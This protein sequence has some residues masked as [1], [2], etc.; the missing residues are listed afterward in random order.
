MEEEFQ[1]VVCGGNWWDSSINLFAS[2]PCSTAVN[3]SGCL[4]P[5]LVKTA[6]SISNN[7]TGSASSVVLQEAP[8]PQN[9][10]IDS[11]FHMNA[12]D[13]WNQDLIHDS[14][15]SQ[16]NYSYMNNLELTNS[17]ANT[18]TSFPLNTSSLLHTL[19]EAD[20]TQPLLENPATNF[21]SPPNLRP[22]FP[23]Q[24]QIASNF[25]L[26]NNAAFWNATAGASFLPS[27]TPL[28]IPSALAKPKLNHQSFGSKA[29]GADTAAMKDG[30][31]PS[32]KRARIET[33]SPTFKVSP[34]REARG[35]NY[36]APAD[37]FTLWKEL[38]I[39]T[40]SVLHEA[41]DYIKLLHDQ[42][43]VQ[44]TPYLKNGPPPLQR[45]QV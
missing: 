3:D 29:V 25:Q 22:S 4:N 10:A 31:G 15:I 28:L 32:L 6:K 17:V 44:S 37:G 5:I 24:Q 2:S 9:M 19:F 39:D 13:N 16:Q 38:E 23:K 40:A 41:I 11:T 12:D 8:K 27:S 18:A 7:S 42:V 21:V 35:P 45:Q 34:K 36:C 43:N 26:I 1:S 30:N 14:A 33:P 20:D